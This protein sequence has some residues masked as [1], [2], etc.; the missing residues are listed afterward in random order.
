ML[1]VMDNYVLLSKDI[2]VEQESTKLG[3]SKTFF[4]GDDFVVVDTSD[5]KELLRLAGQARNKRKV[6]IYRPP[7]EEL[8]RFALEK[9]SVKGVIGIEQIHPKDNVHAVRG[10]LDQ[11]L[12]TIAAEKKKTIYFSFSDMLNSTS[13]A[14]FLARMMFNVRLCRKYN[15]NIGF[16]TF[17]TGMEELRSARDLG[18]LWEVLSVKV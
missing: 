8:L 18:V 2:A 16:S 13:R 15:L 10:G 12:C 4:L 14:K 7:T 5:P 9:T 11:V 6:V 17:A 3:F 1:I